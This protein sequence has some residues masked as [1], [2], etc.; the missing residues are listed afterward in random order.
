MH[1]SRTMR[2]FRLMKIPGDADGK[3][4]ATQHQIIGKFDHACV[5]LALRQSEG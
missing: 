3:E 2:F 5:L 4:D 1:I